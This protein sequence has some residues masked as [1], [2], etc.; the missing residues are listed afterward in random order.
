MTRLKSCPRQC[1]PER[2]SAWVTYL[3][4]IAIAVALAC[5]A[6]SI[7]AENRD[8][9]GSVRYPHA[10]QGAGRH[11]DISS[12]VTYDAG[13]REWDVAPWFNPTLLLQRR[14]NGTRH[15][16]AGHCRPRAGDPARWVFGQWQNDLGEPHSLRATRPTHCGDRQRIWRRGD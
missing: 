9:N 5:A 12:P 13:A 4:G 3:P 6:P 14:D 8:T 11:L 16:T 10:D 2:Q 15:I 7:R 1:P